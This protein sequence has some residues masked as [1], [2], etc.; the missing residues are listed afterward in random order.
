M[1]DDQD[2]RGRERTRQ[3]DEINSLVDSF[4]ETSLTSSSNSCTN[5]KLNKRVSFQDSH[6]PN[7]AHSISP[8]TSIDSFI[9]DSNGSINDFERSGRPR[10]LRTHTEPQSRNKYFSPSRHHYRIPASHTLLKE[11]SNAS[12]RYEISDGNERVYIN[13]YWL[14]DEIGRGSCGTV[15]LAID[16]TTGTKYAIKVY[17]KQRLRRNSLSSILRQIQIM[18][19]LSHVNVARMIEVLDDPMSDNLFC[20]MEYCSRGVIMK[21]AMDSTVKHYSEEQ[22]RLYFRDLILGIEYLHSRGIVHRDIKPENLLLSEDDVLKIT[23]FGVSEIFESSNTD[24]LSYAAGSPAF[25]APEIV[26]GTS[27]SML[28]PDVWS[29]GVTLYCLA[30]GHLP[31]RHFHLNELYDSIKYDEPEL[32]SNISA[33]LIDLIKKLLY[34]DPLTR[35]TLFKVRVHPWVTLN[36]EDE[37]LSYEE[38]TSDADFNSAVHA[39]FVVVKVI[40][41]V[42][43]L[44][45]M[46]E[47]RISSSTKDSI[48]MSVAKEQIKSKFNRSR[49]AD[50]GSRWSPFLDPHAE[51]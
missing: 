29:M 16:T 51:E 8:S 5:L 42:R 44:Q 11:T 21:M 34:K 18:N 36:G 46:A 28:T 6:S 17:S 40:K 13:Q 19:R 14:Q 26:M 48:R 31:F 33:E 41:A 1:S 15:H 47:G 20:V 3:N 10:F 35:I 22:C 38:N 27:I 49:S 37:L 7:G 45:A 9:G 32:P 2:S 43:I 50:P 23:D 25:M 39:A 4:A 12:S 24:G 30:L